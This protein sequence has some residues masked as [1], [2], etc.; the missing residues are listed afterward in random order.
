M[1]RLAHPP[2]TQNS[3]RS[4]GSAPGQHLNEQ[5][6]EEEYVELGAVSHSGSEGDIS[7]EAGWR[8]FDQGEVDDSLLYYRMHDM[9]LPGMCDE[10][11]HHSSAPRPSSGFLRRR[12][13]R[14]DGEAR[15]KK[16]VS[17]GGGHDSATELQSS[18]ISIS[19]RKCTAWVPNSD[20]L[21][22]LHCERPFNMMRRRHHCRMCGELVCGQCSPHRV[23]LTLGP[24]GSLDKL[25]ISVRK[26]S[27]RHPVRVCTDCYF[28]LKSVAIEGRRVGGNA[29]L[30]GWGGREHRP[31]IEHV[32]D[33]SEVDYG[34]AAD[35][36]SRICRN[37][38][39][40][41]ETA[42]QG[43][44]FV[45]E[46]LKYR[47]IKVHLILSVAVSAV[48]DFRMLREIGQSAPFFPQ[49]S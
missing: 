17:K 8:D 32:G 27:A 7:V 2:S 26:R 12:W 47:C 36:S 14:L 43:D 11:S 9:R 38:C 1:R 45:W 34:R 22:C 41:M 16:M 44:A 25:S 40:D 35:D 15:R 3:N 48:S 49:I 19:A 33:E 13:K 18:Q 4:G 21:T 42:M 29:D 23:K 6:T 10:D 24:H 20:R 30:H 28:L 37:T 5:R 46:R 31:C 39:T